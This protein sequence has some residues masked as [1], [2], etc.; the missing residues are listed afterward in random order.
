MGQIL[1]NAIWILDEI[2]FSPARKVRSARSYKDHK[3]TT[4]P[5]LHLASFCRVKELGYWNF[6]LDGLHVYSWLS[7]QQFSRFL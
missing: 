4:R 2:G 5:V 3:R 1:L 6:L 7:G